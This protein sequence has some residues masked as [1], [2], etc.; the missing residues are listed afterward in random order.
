MF[1]VIVQILKLIYSITKISP[2]Y[3]H[4]YYST[5][6]YW[7]LRYCID[8]IN[9]F[10]RFDYFQENYYFLVSYFVELFIQMNI[11]RCGV[12]NN[13][14]AN[15]LNN[16]HTPRSSLGPWCRIII[17]FEKSPFN[18]CHI[19]QIFF[20]IFFFTIQKLIFLKFWYLFFELFLANPNLGV[21]CS[22]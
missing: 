14:F 17:I 3:T 6:W 15:I 8:S 9:C 12:I 11:E 2:F 7:Q 19:L 13:K 16:Y 18:K 21:Q 22:T 10:L 5:S 1:F 4:F 20:K